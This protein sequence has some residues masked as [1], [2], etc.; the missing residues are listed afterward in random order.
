MVEQPGFCLELP[1]PPSVNGVWRHNRNGRHFIS[2]SAKAWARSFELEVLRSGIAPVK[3]PVSIHIEAIPGDNFRSNR[4]LDNTFKFPID[5]LRKS[6]LIDGDDIQTVQRITASV[7]ER[8]KDDKAGGIRLLV[9]PIPV[10][11]VVA[12]LAPRKRGDGGKHW[13][14]RR[15]PGEAKGLDSDGQGGIRHNDQ[16]HEVKPPWR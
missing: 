14:T 2:P 12:V 5:C 4:D 8:S 16:A 3:G 11:E 1:A 10:A 7:G 15:K 13:K 6:G 9:V